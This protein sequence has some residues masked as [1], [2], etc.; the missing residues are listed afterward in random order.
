M[1]THTTAQRHTAEERHEAILLAAI[2]EFAVHGLHGASTDAIAKKVGIS[3]PYIFKIFGT[4]K[5][6]FLAAV[7]RIYANTRA[8]F[9]TGLQQNDGPPLDAMGKAFE[10]LVTGRDELLMLLQSAAAVGDPEI[11]DHVRTR[12]TALATFVRDQ[13]GVS[14]FEANMF[15]GYGLF[16]ALASAADFD[17]TD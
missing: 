2:S 17:S 11:R 12:F 10:N 1:R 8:A 4:K 9:V 3:Q 7:E 14:D 16:L 6:L 13:A 5:E 15:M